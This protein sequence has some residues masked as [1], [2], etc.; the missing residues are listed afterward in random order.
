MELEAPQTASVEP[1][2]DIP[3]VSLFAG[4]GG[5]DLGFRGQGFLPIVAIDVNQAAVDSYN[6]NDSRGIA[7]K[8]DLRELSDEQ[9]ISLVRQSAGE[10]IP[11]GVIG[12]PPCQGVSTSNVYRKRHDPR[13]KLLIRYARIVQAL[14]EAFNL[15]FFVFENVVGLKSKKH[16]RYF[17]KIID[18]LE[19]AGFSIFEKELDAKNFGVAQRRNRVF[20][21]G[22]NRRSF[23]GIKFDFPVGSETILTIREAIGGLPAPL[24]FQRKLNPKDIPHH[25][26]H[27]AMNP[28]S[29]KFLNGVRGKG[30]SFRRLEWDQPSGTVAYGHREM[31]VHPDG[32]R[33][34][35]IYEG[36][37]FQGFPSGY[38]LLGTFSEQ[39]DQVSNAVPPPLAAA[40]AREIRWAL[41]GR[42]S[43]VQTDLLKWFEQNARSFPW[44]ETRDPYKVLVAE[45]LLQQTAATERVIA[46]YLQ[47]VS[48]YPTLA[49]LARASAKDLTPIIF[50]LGFK[51]RAKELPSLARTIVKNKSSTIP[52]DQKSLL[53]LPGVG[54]YSARAILSFGYGRDLAVVDT[55]VA[56]FLTRCFGLQFAPSQN[57]ARSRALQQ[58]ADGLVPKGKSS[59]FNWA[60][61]DLCA[62]H[63]K[64][65]KPDC[66][67]CPVR[68]S[69]SYYAS[70]QP[71]SVA[72][73]GAGQT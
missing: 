25:P 2:H 69:C 16:R 40:I 4:A 63:C 8:G 43:K 70:G 23:P 68:A 48:E 18:T 39:V 59:Q 17:H 5:M 65:R 10:R 36:M 21:V 20:I 33:R 11:R 32:T 60:I 50:P 67:N 9:I 19:D 3:I 35:S 41:Y 34:V 14:T 73:N 61:L 26:N 71:V 66:N 27:W 64:A 49:E 42:A 31:H 38:Q 51:Y 28:R 13:K 47:L 37:L 55:N 1:D 7:K 72:A 15:D 62:A 46:A 44:R 29:P 12:G 58:V 52:N 53:S 30:R 6:L 22:I 57:P 54:D 56:R 45:K 24:F